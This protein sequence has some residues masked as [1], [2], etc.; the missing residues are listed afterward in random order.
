[1]SLS[2]AGLFFSES[3]MLWRER[4]FH[5]PEG[6]KRKE[7]ESFRW[8]TLPGEAMSRRKRRGEMADG[9][10]SLAEKKLCQ[11]KLSCKGGM[12]VWKC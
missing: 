6:K 3:F 1:M 2:S 5:Y 7:D 12:K 9:C 11:S 4:F 8:M 10:E